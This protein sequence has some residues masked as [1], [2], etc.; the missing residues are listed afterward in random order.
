MCGPSIVEWEIIASHP[1]RHPIPLNA[2]PVITDSYECALTLA[3]QYAR[4]Q[5]WE[6]PEYA[7]D[8]RRARRFA[9]V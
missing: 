8:V 5:H 4:E 6:I 7:L 1:R 3:I 2:P 9:C